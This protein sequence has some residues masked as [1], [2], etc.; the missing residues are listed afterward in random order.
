MTACTM[1]EH[2]VR[3]PDDS[4]AP[5][6]ARAFLGAVC[7]GRHE[8]RVLDE[9]QLLVSELVSNA[10]RHGVPPIELEVGCVGRDSMRIRV[11]DCGTAVPKP[12]EADADAEGGRGLM[13]V[14][15]VSSDWG[16]DV[17]A[18]GKVV[19]FTLAV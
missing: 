5:S 14:D 7:C 15:L 19:W 18:D 2:K 13:L 12:R 3:L 11:R 17:D 9:A 8:A 10:V 16:H 4:T 6:I 1:K